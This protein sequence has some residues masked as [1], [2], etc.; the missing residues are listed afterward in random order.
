MESSIQAI[1]FDF[2]GV[3]INW[4]P[5]ELFNKYFSDDRQAIDDFLAEINF[6]TWNLSQD[7]GYPFAK[8]VMELSARYPQYAH[9]IRAYDEEWEQSITGVIPETVDILYKLKKAGYRLYGLTNWSAEKFAIV[10]HKYEAFKL[11][12]VIVVSGEVKLV[13][14][15][16]AIFRLLLQKIRRQ[17]EECLLVDDSL[18]NIETAQKMGFATHHFTSPALLERQLKLLGLL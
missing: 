18:Q 17:P 16:P 10:K 13:K 7:G 2:G 6:P 14:P 11:F 8:A 1:I 4:D 5:H 12:E 3:L 15:D 9:L